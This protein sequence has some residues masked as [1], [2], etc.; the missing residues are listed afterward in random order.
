VFVFRGGYGETIPKYL[1]S[2]WRIQFWES[3]ALLLV[4]RNTVLEMCHIV[5]NSRIYASYASSNNANVSPKP[6]YKLYKNMSA[7]I[8]P[9]IWTVPTVTSR[10]YN[11]LILM[12]YGWEV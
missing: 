5:Y 4:N 10:Q 3:C 2:F 9:T 6:Y 11:R 7:I 1:L 12:T 8:V